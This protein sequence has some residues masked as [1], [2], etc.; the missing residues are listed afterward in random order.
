MIKFV[1]AKFKRM[2]LLTDGRYLVLTFMSSFSVTAS[3]THVVNTKLENVCNMHCVNRDC[4]IHT[5]IVLLHKILAHEH[6]I[7]YYNR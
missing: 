4:A 5:H 3:G 2:T 6:C 7:I 1:N